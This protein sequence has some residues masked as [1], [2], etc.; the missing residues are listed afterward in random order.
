VTHRKT[1]KERQLAEG[2]RGGGWEGAKSYDSK[3][4]WSSINHSIL[5]ERYPLWFCPCTIDMYF[6]DHVMA[7]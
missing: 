7:K 5:L 6:V 1:E 2:G 3:K 4:G